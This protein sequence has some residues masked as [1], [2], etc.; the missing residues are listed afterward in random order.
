[1]KRDLVSKAKD[2]TDAVFGMTLD[3][4]P[5]HLCISEGPHWLVCGQT[6]SGK[7]VFLNSMILSLLYQSTPNE[8]QFFIVDPKFIDFAVY[9]NLPYCPCPPA[10]TPGDAFALLQYL[11]WLMDKRYEIMLSAGR[12]NNTLIKNLNDFNE[13]YDN[14][15]EKAVSLGFERMKYTILVIDEFSDL[16]KQDKGGVEECVVRLAQK[17]RACGIHLIISTQRPSVDV[18]TGTIKANIPSRVA[19]KVTSSGNS[20]IILDETGAEKLGGYGDALVQ[21]PSGIVRCK[22]P[23]FENKEMERIFDYLKKKYPPPIL[24]DYKQICVDND[25]MEWE[26]EYDENVSWEEKH[27]IGKRRRNSFSL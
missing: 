14:N 17:S 18:I 25:L 13:W 21:T 24:V 4:M 2:P 12:M 3:G 23:F 6:G 7:S 8:L 5:Y 1:M 27:V 15:T 19:L 11:T 16:V 26:K 20:M 9:E 10:K 22:G